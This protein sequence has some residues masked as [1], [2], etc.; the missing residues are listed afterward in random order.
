MLTLKETSTS[1]ATAPDSM[2][3]WKS[4]KYISD[5]NI[6]VSHE[7]GRCLAREQEGHSMAAGHVT[8]RAGR[9]NSQRYAPL[10]THESYW[11]H[12][13]TK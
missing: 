13:K 4:Y 9:D 6:H 8:A 5:K 3:K 7:E 12:I 1:T 2:Q 10:D 11:T